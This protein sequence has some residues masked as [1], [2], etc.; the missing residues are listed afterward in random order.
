MPTKKSPVPVYQKEC[1]EKLTASVLSAFSPS[2]IPTIVL[3]LEDAKRCGAK[4]VV[5]TLISLAALASPNVDRL[6]SRQHA[7]ELD[8]F[9]FSLV[10]KP[11]AIARRAP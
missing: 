8:S 11:E 4:L 3:V 1:L 5:Q 7:M 10:R 9:F 2:Y 6:P